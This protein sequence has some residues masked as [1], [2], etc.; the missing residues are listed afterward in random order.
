MVQPELL[1]SG[2]KRLSY[3]EHHTSCGQHA[4][5]GAAQ[6]ETEQTKIQLK[7]LPMFSEIHNYSFLFVCFLLMP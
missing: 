7:E 4:D 1:V 3:A 6:E 2:K 5:L